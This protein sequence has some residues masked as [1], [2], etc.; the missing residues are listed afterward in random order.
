M[1][2]TH[3]DRI[4]HHCLPISFAKV[5]EDFL[6]VLASRPCIVLLSRGA[7]TANPLDLLSGFILFTLC[8]LKFLKFVGHG[9][10]KA[11]LLVLVQRV[12]D[13]EL[14]LKPIHL[15]LWKSFNRCTSSHFSLAFWK[16]TD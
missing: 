1:A 12:K 15:V 13:Q 4:G 11:M 5:V 16:R 9:L 3:P 14:I 10:E 7:T 8:W 2:K 6:S